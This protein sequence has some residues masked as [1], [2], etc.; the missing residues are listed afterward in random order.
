MP[1][2]VT[3]EQLSQY[4]EKFGWKYYTPREEEREKE[5]IIYTGWRTA[6][7]DTF[8]MSIDPMVEK[9]CLSFRVYNVV[10]APWSETPPGYLADLLA[11]LTWIN[12]RII[13]GKFAYD[14]TDGQVRL[15][16]DMPIDENDLTYE[17]FYHT[18]RVALDTAEKWRPILGRL[19]SGEAQLGEIVLQEAQ[20]GG[21]PEEL[22]AKLRDNLAAWG[23]WG[24]ETPLTEI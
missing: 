6:S 23:G 17:Q 24:S 12:Y 4:L 8:N 13:L 5:G 22:L 7:E 9:G 1:T 20:E 16:L 11:L 10:K 3:M 21:F 15:T 19:L 18:M 2:S 14:M